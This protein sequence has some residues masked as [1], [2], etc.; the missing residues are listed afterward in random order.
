MKDFFYIIPYFYDKIKGFAQ[1]LVFF[2][3]FTI[4]FQEN[5][6]KRSDLRFQFK[7]FYMRGPIGTQQISPEIARHAKKV[8]AISPF[9]FSFELMLI[10]NSHLQIQRLTYAQCW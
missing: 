10:R 6:I 9:L 1:K 5:Q 2:L 4:Y 7:I 3:H 8:K